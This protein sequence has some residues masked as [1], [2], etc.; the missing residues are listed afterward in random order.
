MTPSNELRIKAMELANGNGY[1]TTPEKVVERAEK[2]YA[3]LIADDKEA[4]T[5]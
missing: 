3:F 4:G 1:D 5:P 2:Y